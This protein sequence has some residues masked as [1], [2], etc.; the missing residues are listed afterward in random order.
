MATGVRRR[1]RETTETD[2]KTNGGSAPRRRCCYAADVTISLA[3]AEEKT[4][5]RSARGI[6]TWVLARQSQYAV[7]H[8]F[9]GGQRHYDVTNAGILHFTNRFTM[10]HRGNRKKIILYC[11]CVTTKYISQTITTTMIII[12]IILHYYNIVRVLCFSAAALR[13]II[14]SYHSGLHVVRVIRLSLLTFTV[15][16]YLH[17]TFCRLPRTR[18]ARHQ[19]RPP[20]WLIRGYGTSSRLIVHLYQRRSADGSSSHRV[21]LSS[22][23]GWT[24]RLFRCN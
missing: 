9:G 13:R 17:T 12:V 16:V 19:Q 6:R 21:A 3:S 24:L 10:R 23:D 11:V 22:Y 4:I 2:K 7:R 1:H 20:V 15:R 8:I 18:A 14:P 5:S